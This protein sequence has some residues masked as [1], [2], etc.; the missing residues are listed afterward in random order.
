MLW[1][2]LSIARLL[3]VI[4]STRLF[5]AGDILKQNLKPSVYLLL[6]S[7]ARSFFWFLFT[8]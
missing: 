7:V 8:P 5:F 1:E 6:L 2:G 3:I 4:L